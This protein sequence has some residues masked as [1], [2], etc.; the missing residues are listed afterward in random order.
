MSVDQLSSDKLQ[1]CI[2]GQLMS[3]QLLHEMARMREYITARE[4]ILRTRMD[5]MDKAITLTEKYPTAIDIAIANV[6]G[7]TNEQFK[8]LE[9]KLIERLTALQN[10]INHTDQNSVARYTLMDEKIDA[11]QELSKERIET[12]HSDITSIQAYQQSLVIRKDEFNTYKDQVL[13]R[14][15][16]NDQEV[17]TALDNAKE[18][19]NMRNNFVTE[20]YVKSENS[21]KSE[22]LLLSNKVDLI[23]RT[24]DAKIDA[25]AKTANEKIDDIR[26]RLTSMESVKTGASQTIVW[27]FAG[28]AAVY[29]LLATVAVIVVLIGGHH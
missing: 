5:A 7:Q 24:E 12:I 6:K 3:E 28:I 16:I 25:N 15:K 27:I 9:E 22:L 21:F 1:E 19:V 11:I 17:A 4:E 23:S 14:F 8:G 26:T 18:M 2:P 10:E 13:E 20:M 29:G